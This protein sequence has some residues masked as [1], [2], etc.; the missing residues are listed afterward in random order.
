M[1]QIH[2]A[3]NVVTPNDVLNLIRRKIKNENFN[4]VKNNSLNT[5]HF[6]TTFWEKFFTNYLMVFIQSWYIN[7]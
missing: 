4:L 6:D 2:D 1:D 5:V 3:F 7:T